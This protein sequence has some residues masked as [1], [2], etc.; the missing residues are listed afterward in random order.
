MSG[1]NVTQYVGSRYV[2]DTMNDVK[3][4]LHDWAL[5]LIQIATEQPE[6]PLAFTVEKPE[7]E[8]PFG[9]FVTVIDVLNHNV[10]YPPPTRAGMDAM[11]DAMFENPAMTPLLRS[12]ANFQDEYEYRHC[13]PVMLAHWTHIIKPA[14]DQHVSIWRLKEQTAGSSDTE[15]ERQERPAGTVEVEQSG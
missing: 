12:P 11:M 6:I 7:I 2:R 1:T 8:D 5:Y 4:E 14:W 15:G 9:F 10:S 13:A 3:P